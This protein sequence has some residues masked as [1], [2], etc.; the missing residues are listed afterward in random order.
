MK[1]EYIILISIIAVVIIIDFISKK[2]KAKK[3]T[4]TDDITEVINE[5]SPVTK[6]PLWLSMLYSFL[7]SLL[8]SVSIYL[9]KY[10]ILNNK[11]EEY[12]KLQDFLILSFEDA[13]YNL[14]IFLSYFIISLIGCILLFAYK[15]IKN[16]KNF[17]G[18]H[19]VAQNIKT[20]V[21]FL[22]SLTFVKPLLHYLL[23]PKYVERLTGAVANTDSRRSFGRNTINT[24][25]EVRASFGDHIYNIKTGEFVFF[26]DLPA[27][28]IPSVILVALLFWLI[29]NK[30]KS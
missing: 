2:I 6:R 1:T 26:T 19:F 29:K 10:H 21:T 5:S 28:F 4:I 7:T 24:Y 18:F 30:I 3:T 8:L 16:I 20:V 23:Y 9:I 22:I 13:Y 12:K 15:D 11:Y 17:K 27:L 14:D 25:K